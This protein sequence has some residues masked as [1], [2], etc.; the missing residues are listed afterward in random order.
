MKTGSITRRR[1]LSAG[2]MMACGMALAPRRIFAQVAAPDMIAQARAAAASAKITTQA[3]R[4]NVTA[5]MGSGGNIAVLTGKDGKVL[6]DSGFMTSQPQITAALNQLSADPMTHLI[7]THWHFDHTDGNEWMHGAGATIL[8]HENTKKRLSEPV[9]IE[10]FHYTFQPAPAGARPT[11]TMTDAK[12]LKLNGATMHLAHYAPAH[13]D[14]D[15]S[16]HFAEADVLH[17]GDTFFNGHY[18]FIDY[19]TGG[20]INGMIAATDHN[21]S[22]VTEKTIVIPG[23]GPVGDRAAL[24]QFRDMLVFSR[25]TVGA[26]KKQGKTLEEVTAAKPL[27]SYDTKWGNSAAM[28]LGLVYQGV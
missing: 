19:S 21:L 18:P 1:F 6:I 27:A 24:Q 10:S 13:T 5:V 3:L 9:T 7:N 20:S 11:E 28:Y 26:L 2:S 8:A 14:T 23:H 17:C 22:M 25:D 15:I 12:T 4:G 16:I